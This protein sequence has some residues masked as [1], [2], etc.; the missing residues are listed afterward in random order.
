M[1][2]LRVIRVMDNQDLRGFKRFL[3]TK[4]VL[5][6]RHGECVVQINAARTLVRFVD[7][8]GG[9]H[10]YEPEGEVDVEALRELVQQGLGVQLTQARSLKK[11][12]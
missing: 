11:V 2:M 5:G 10:R 4:V 1:T 9:V 7:S 6:L 3:R 8:V 12:A